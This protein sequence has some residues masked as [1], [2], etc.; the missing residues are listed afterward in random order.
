VLLIFFI[1]PDQ[2]F[3]ASNYEPQQINNKTITNDPSI[4]LYKTRNDLTNISR[5][6]IKNKLSQKHVTSTS[7]LYNLSN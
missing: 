6:I 2:Q 4:Q 7:A 5:E 3:Y 1:V